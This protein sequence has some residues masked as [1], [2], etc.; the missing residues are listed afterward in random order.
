MFGASLSP[1]P[2]FVSDPAY[3]TLSDS[4][5]GS[6]GGCSYASDGSFNCRDDDGYHHRRQKADDRKVQLVVGQRDRQAR[7][8]G[9]ADR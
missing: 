1:D 5:G 8:G 6:K 7:W 9:G 4:A 3:R 2:I